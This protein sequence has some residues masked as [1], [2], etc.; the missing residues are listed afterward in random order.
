[1]YLYQDGSLKSK[2]R[3]Q[4]YK[5]KTSLKSIS[6]RESKNIQKRNKIYKEIDEERPKI[7]SGCGQK[8]FLSHAHLISQKNKKYQFDKR[9]IVFDCMQRESS[10]QFGSMG[11]HAR[12]ESGDIRKIKTLLNKEYR[13]EFLK[14]HDKEK[15]ER[16][17]AKAP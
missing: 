9:N 1:M 17:F 2:K 14:T 3:G 13:L 15:Y 7:C 5:K 11:C 10:D 6:K 16:I 4:K 12:W 8:S